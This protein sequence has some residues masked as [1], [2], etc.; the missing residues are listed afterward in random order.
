MWL[1]KQQRVGI[2][3]TT[4]DRI[5]DPLRPDESWIGRDS[6]FGIRDPG[7]GG[8]GQETRS[9]LESSVCVTGVDAAHCIG[10]WLGYRSPSWKAGNHRVVAPAWTTQH[11]RMRRMLGSQVIHSINY[12]I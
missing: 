6:G 8:K 12:I 5:T 10:M 9:A 1:T 11:A 7:F 3:P 4:P 2:S